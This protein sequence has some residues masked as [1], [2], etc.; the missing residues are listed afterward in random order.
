MHELPDGQSISVREEGQQLGEALIRP[1]LLGLDLPDLP[2]AVITQIM[3]HP[4][5]PTRKVLGYCSAV[6][7]SNWD[8]IAY[9]TASHVPDGAICRSCSRLMAQHAR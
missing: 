4:D 2:S 8:I 5:G 7:P 6:L 3:Q 9:F 1:S